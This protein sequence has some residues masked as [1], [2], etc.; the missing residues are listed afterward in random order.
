MKRQKTHIS[1]LLYVMGPHTKLNTHGINVPGS[2]TATVMF[3]ENFIFPW[4]LTAFIDFVSRSVDVMWNQHIFI[5]NDIG[6]LLVLSI[7]R[8]SRMQKQV[9]S[10]CFLTQLIIKFILNI[11]D[12]PFCNRDFS[13]NHITSLDTT[14]DISF[15]DFSPW[16][17][18]MR[19]YCHL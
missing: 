2:L 12:S 17:S 7:S 15:H 4:V 14:E 10:L 6:L 8:L 18:H 1:L 3:N 13:T 5:A 11:F 9:L 16:S 19:S